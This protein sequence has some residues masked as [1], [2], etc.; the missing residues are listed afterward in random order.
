MK[1]VMA[2]IIGCSLVVPAFVHVDSDAWSGCTTEQ[3]IELG[4]QGY[5]GDEVEKACSWDTLSRGFSSGLTDGLSKALGGSG[6][7]YVQRPLTVQVCVARITG[8]AL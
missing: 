5:G 3:R 7:T 4:N 2:V 8:R 6:N 1:H